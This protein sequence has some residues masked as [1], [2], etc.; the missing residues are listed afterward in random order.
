MRTEVTPPKA[1]L[2]ITPTGRGRS[3]ARPRRRPR[4]PR[5]ISARSMIRAPGVTWTGSGSGWR[6]T[7]TLDTAWDRRRWRR[8][9]SRAARRRRTRRDAWDAPSAPRRCRGVCSDD[10]HDGAAP[11][12]VA[13][14]ETSRAD[15]LSRTSD[16]RRR[17]QV[18][19]LAGHRPPPSPSRDRSQWRLPRRAGRTRP[20]PLTVAG[21][22]AVSAPR[23]LNRAGLVAARQLAQAA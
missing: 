16:E 9:G 20:S 23:S 13:A 22:A 5:S 19:W 4:L 15:G 12:G 2:R 11:G 10:P 17:R 7:T 18:S 1:P 14:T 3:T 8:Q 6:L 21:T